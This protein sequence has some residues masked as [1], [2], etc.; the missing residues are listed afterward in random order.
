MPVAVSINWKAKDVIR[1]LAAMKRAG[2]NLQ[3]VFR[4]LGKPLRQDLKERG[5]SKMGEDGPWAP[6]A[7]ATVERDKRGKTVKR[8]GGKSR[9]FKRRRKRHLLGK[10]PTSV[11]TR[12]SRKQLL[13]QSRIPFSGAHQDGERVGRGVVLPARSHVY[14]SDKILDRAEVEIIDYVIHRGWERGR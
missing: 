11:S 2:S 8:K 14:F 1:G 4:E 3:P 7:P 10:L 5:R 13:G 6:R 9:T 12:S